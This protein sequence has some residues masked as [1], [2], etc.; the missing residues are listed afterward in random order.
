MHFGSGQ[1][2][3]IYLGKLRAEVGGFGKKQSFHRIF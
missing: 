3:G 2:R 1:F